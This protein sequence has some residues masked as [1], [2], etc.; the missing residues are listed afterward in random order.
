M[1]EASLFTIATECYS[2]TGHA[3]LCW[4]R[5]L[6]TPIKIIRPSDSVSRLTWASERTPAPGRVPQHPCQEFAVIRF[7]ID[8]IR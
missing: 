7:S 4:L 5:P 2:K 6:S 1:I 3:E 8:V